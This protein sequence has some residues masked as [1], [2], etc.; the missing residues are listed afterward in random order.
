MIPAC[1]LTTRAGRPAAVQFLVREV[2][3][4]P[5]LLGQQ[6]ALV[7]EPL[8]RPQQPLCLALAARDQLCVAGEDAVEEFLPEGAARVG[9]E[10]DRGQLRDE[11]LAPV[12]T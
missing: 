2:G 4:V 5:D 3:R 9:V 1:G 6:P 8:Q 12:S 7:G 11:V 10:G